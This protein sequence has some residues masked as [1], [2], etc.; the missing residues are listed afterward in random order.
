MLRNPLLVPD[1]RELILAGE[2]SALAEFLADHHPAHVAEIIEDLGDSEGDTA[3]CSLPDRTRAEVMSYV[4]PDRQVRV[5]EGMP[6]TEAASLLHLMSHDDR[7]H[8]FN[9]LDDDDRKDEILRNLAQAE[10]EDIRRLASYEPGTAGSY[11]T[12]DYATLLPGLTRREALDRLRREAPDRET[13]DYSY[14][15]DADH[16]LLGIVPFTRLFLAKQLDTVEQIMQRDI[17]S[18]RVDEDREVAA[19]KVDKYDLNAL[20][21]LDA[22]DRLV[23]IVTHDDAMDILRQ[24]QTEDILAFGGVAA[25]AEDSDEGNYWQGRITSAVHRRIGWLLLLFLAGSITSRIIRGFHWVDLKLPDLELEAF[26]PLLIG[27]GG[28]AGSQTV[29]TV[30]RGLALNQI[31]PSDTLKVVAREALTG[32]VL[33]LLLGSISFLFAWQ[34]EP[35]QPKFGL[36]IALA[37]LGICVWANAIGALVP[38]LASRF[39]IDPALVSAPLI[40][41][42]VDTTGLVIFYSIAI[43]LLIR[44]V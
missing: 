6:P 19:R 37:I 40:S 3:L 20:P 16:K 41:T 12:T 2:T 1:L 7:A 33:G 44:M 17:I 28:N 32:L 39:K 42:L 43:V 21:I 38:L 4:E 13:I 15:V 5:V 9:R 29:S 23:G 27:T 10:R 36:V 22:S 30:I 25:P 18:A 34:T 14:V 24:E 35:D 8:L 31:Q 26:I 11:M